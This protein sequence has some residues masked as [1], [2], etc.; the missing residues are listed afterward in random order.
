MK[1]FKDNWLIVVLIT[2]VIFSLLKPIVCNVAQPSK[3]DKTQ[4]DS[5]ATIIRENNFASEQVLD[6]IKKSN[7][8]IKVALVSKEAKIG[9]LQNKLSNTLSKLKGYQKQI[10]STDT[11]VDVLAYCDS[12]S[13]QLND[14]VDLAEEIISGKDSIIQ[15]QQNVITGMEKEVD[16][17]KRSNLLMQ[18]SF[19]TLHSKYNDLYRIAN[20]NSKISGLHKVKDKA[21]TIAAVVLGIVL[22][23]K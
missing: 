17:Y 19:D 3:K 8:N 9:A 12:L 13:N 10:S 14:Y 2:T 7:E 15:D 23:T 5:L 6:S 4:V 20:K 21:L 18:S 22:L 16:T 1:W 11:T